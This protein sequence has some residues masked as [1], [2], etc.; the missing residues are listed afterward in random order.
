MKGSSS[1]PK[2]AERELELSIELGV[3]FYRTFIRPDD[4]AR[5]KRRSHKGALLLADQSFSKEVVELMTLF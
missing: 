1:G 3:P 5:S 4:A 2:N